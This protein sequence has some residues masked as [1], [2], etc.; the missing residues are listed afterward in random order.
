MVVVAVIGVLA[1]LALPSFFRESSRGTAKSEVVGVFAELTNKELNYESKK[2]V[3][4][5]AAACPASSTG[6]PQDVTACSASGGV[7]ASLGTL[8]PTATVY[9][10]YQI[11]AGTSAQTAAPPA[12]FTM[13]Q[14]A[15][16]WFFIVATCLVGG[17]TYTFFTCS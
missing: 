4:L 12:G 5:A 6:K 13:R 2:G 17:T 8:M 16:G 10:S 11:T 7:W 9:C 15:T 14:P 1:K 3:Y